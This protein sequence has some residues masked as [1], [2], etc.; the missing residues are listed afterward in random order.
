[1]K[2]EEGK[3]CEKEDEKERKGVTKNNPIIC[4]RQYYGYK[5]NPGI[6]GY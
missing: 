4:I 2:K 1:L 3:E 5:R 6:A